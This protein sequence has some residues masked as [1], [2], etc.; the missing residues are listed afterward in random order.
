MDVDTEGLPMVIQLSKGGSPCELCIFTSSLP[1]A[2]LC[3]P[4]HPCSQAHSNSTSSGG[5]PEN[6]SCL[7]LPHPQ[8]WPALEG[9]S[10]I[11]SAHLLVQGGLKV[12]QPVRHEE[13][14]CGFC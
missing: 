13:V 14:A 9:T 7:W 3:P 8:V 10:V 6:I 5:S 11:L 2:W 4:P 12:Q 1:D